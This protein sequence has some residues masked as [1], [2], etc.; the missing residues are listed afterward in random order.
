MDTSLESVLVT[1]ELDRREARQPDY[2]AESRILIALTRGMATT[3][4]IF[5]SLA[6]AAMTLC[7][8]QS[9]GISLLQA[10]GK[11]FRWPA[12]AGRWA[13]FAGGGTPRDFGPC[14]VVLDRDRALL[15]SHPER[16]FAYLASSAP[17]IDE[18]LLVPFRVGG[19]AVG[20]IWAVSHEPGLRFDRED[21][22]LLT[23]LSEFASAAYRTLLL[24]GAVDAVALR[25]LDGADDPLLASD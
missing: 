10:D 9:A 4:G 5:R 21:L 8:A 23:D 20:T 3:S 25:S 19:K 2:A 6:E 17:S 11:S 24:L 1:E 22:R 13:A 18:A 14:G 16:H 15:F 12:I 7:R